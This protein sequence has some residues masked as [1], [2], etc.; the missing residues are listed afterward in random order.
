[1]FLESSTP[2]QQS[3]RHAQN[4]QKIQKKSQKSAKKS[5]KPAKPTSDIARVIAVS[6]VIISALVLAVNIA[7]NEIYREDRVAERALAALAKDY[8]ENYYYDRV[9][10]TSSDPADAL[11]KY[12]EI[13]IPSISLRQLLLVDNRRFAP[14]AS[15]FK[16]SRYACNN[17]QTTIKIYPKEPF[18]KTDYEVKLNLSC[19]WLNS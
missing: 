7:M 11:K 16:N 2:A 8:Y 6:A 3:R 4:L 12:T 19:S 9:K 13:G 10:S 5:K 17:E 15:S 18:E 14:Y 1:M